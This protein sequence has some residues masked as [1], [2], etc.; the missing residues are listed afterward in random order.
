MDGRGCLDDGIGIIDL[1]IGRR[2]AQE[3]AQEDSRGGLLK[4]DSAAYTKRI[5]F[6]DKAVAEFPPYYRNKNSPT[7][8]VK[9]PYKK[10]SSSAKGSDKQE[11]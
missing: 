3:G 1:L 2:D 9:V 8:K 4:K 5:M 10:L 6:W 7:W 11:L